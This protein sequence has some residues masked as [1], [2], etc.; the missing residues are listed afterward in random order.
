MPRNT[1]LTKYGEM[2]LV[3][4][5]IL[6]AYPAA[7]HFTR[8]R[9]GAMLPDGPRPDMTPKEAAMLGVFRRIADVVVITPS[10]LVVI[11]A[12]IRSDTGDPSK[13]VVYGRLVP[14]TPE[15][16]PYLDRRLVLELVVAI[17]DPVVR[18]VAQEL[19]IRTRVF[20]PDWLPL[21]VAQL[22]RRERRPVQA[23]GLLGAR[24]EEP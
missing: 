5:Y 8:M 4:E 10:E 16:K 24:E 6:Q 14:F 7:L 12:S 13:L 11:E 9:L 18:M 20:K 23:R 1:D 2:R 21:Y 17:E 15:L 19:G 3:G 22:H